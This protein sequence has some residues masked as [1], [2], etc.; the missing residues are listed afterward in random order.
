MISFSAGW[1]TYYM[2]CVFIGML[3]ATYLA[4]PTEY[5]A[6]FKMWALR[7]TEPWREEHA[8]LDLEWRTFAQRHNAGGNRPYCAYDGW[9]DELYPEQ[10]V[11]LYEFPNGDE[12]ADP[13]CLRRAVIRGFTKKELYKYRKEELEK[14]LGEDLSYVPGKVP[15]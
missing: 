14:E 8:S 9:E 4:R 13:D 1:I 2:V 10:K 12:G 3:C 7:V 5:N 15:K 11:E 6:R